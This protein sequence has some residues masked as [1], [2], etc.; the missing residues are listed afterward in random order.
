MASFEPGSGSSQPLPSL[1]G[2]GWALAFYVLRGWRRACL[3]MN[4]DQS[5]KA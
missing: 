1:V 5:A 3:S 4:F 2:V